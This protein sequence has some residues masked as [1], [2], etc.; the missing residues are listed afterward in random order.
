MNNKQLINFFRS[1]L[2]IKLNYFTIGKPFFEFKFQIRNKIVNL[3]LKSL[4]SP[5]EW[6][7][8]DCRN[9]IFLLFSV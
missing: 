9:Q 8:Y 3:S 5:P 6:Q 1:Y 7:L 4:K 2:K